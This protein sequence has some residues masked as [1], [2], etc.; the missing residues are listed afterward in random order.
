MPDQTALHDAVSRIFE[1]EPTEHETESAA[2]KAAFAKETT[3]AAEPS[4]RP[5]EATEDED[6]TPASEAAAADQASET[7][8]PETADE[9][10]PATEEEDTTAIKEALA[11]HGAPSL[12]D[13]PP[14]ARP[15]VEKRL[16]EMQAAFTRA[17]Q[18][19][20]AFRKEKATYDARLAYEKANPVDA[21]VE[22]LLATPT[23]LEQVNEELTKLAEPVYAE[24]KTMRRDAAKDR[25]LVEAEQARKQ[26]EFRESRALHVEQLA[27]T[28]AVKAGIPL[29]LVEESVAYVIR[30]KGDITDQELSSII[31]AKSKVF[32]RHVGVHKREDRKSI[33]KL[34]VEDQK[35][36]LTV[37]PGR[38]TS[39]TPAGKSAPKAKNIEER[40]NQLVGEMDFDAA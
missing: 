3:N 30:E 6:E 13:I 29:A 7:A 9:D 2:D 4:T 16:K 15:L 25:A 35:A 1:D 21:I 22:R 11:K 26:A 33:A 12:A 31:D 5:D 40:F 23:L 17:Q 20:T 28:L 27:E 38:A 37:K 39:A 10:E 19:Q 8:A 36:G 34:K 24:A 18:E 32:K 14:E